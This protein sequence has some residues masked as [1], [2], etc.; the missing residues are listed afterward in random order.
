MIT[1][2]TC[3]KNW[4][5]VKWAALCMLA[6][7]TFIGCDT[8]MPNPVNN[9][10]PGAQPV[11]SE[12]IIL[13][14]GDVVKITIP[15][16]DNL[17]STQPIRRDGKINLSLVGEVAAAGMTP[18]ELQKKLVELYAPQ[19][20]SHEITVEVVSSAFPV[21]V[22][23]AV[24][25]PGKVMSDHPMTALEAI[26]EA[27]GPNFD[28]ANLKEVKIVRTEN[29]VVQ[30]FVVNVKAWLQGADTKPFYLK[31]G[32]IIYVPERMGF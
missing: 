28:T 3:F 1:K 22:T 5:A 15:G 13:R 17:N 12:K 6:A 32:D 30:H 21:F 8:T 11:H 24:A 10:K 14:E 25:K 31:P 26:M 16:S 4:A 7:F 2:I 19:I 27:G 18:D 9:T 29:G 23:G 20:S